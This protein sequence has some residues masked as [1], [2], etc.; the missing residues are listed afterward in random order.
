MSERQRIKLLHHELSNQIF[1]P[2]TIRTT[3]WCEAC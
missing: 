3:A 2:F 1:E